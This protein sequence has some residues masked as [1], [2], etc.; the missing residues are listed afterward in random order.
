MFTVRIKTQD[1]TPGMLLA[2]SVYI[3]AS[4]ADML[5]ARKDTKLDA[6]KIKML[7]ER[8]VP[9]V[10]IV[11]PS[12][13]D[14]K[15]IIDEKLKEEAVDSVKQLFSCFG[16]ESCENKTTAYQ[17]VEQVEDVVDDLVQVLTDD[18]SGLVHIND[19]KSY[20]EYTYHH[21]LS[22][23]MLSIATGREL[24]LDND[25]LFRLG[26][27]AMMHDIGKQL[28]PIEIINKPGKLT[29]KE[30][31][32]IKSHPSLGAESL[33]QNGIGDKELWD[34]VRYHHEKING[35]GYPD[36]IKG[37]DLP[38]FSKI[39]SVVDVYDAVTSYRPYRSPMLPSEAFEII[40]KDIGTAFE[41]DIVK[42]FLAKLELY[43]VNTVV[44]LSNGKIG[45]V[46]QNEGSFRL[47]PTVCLQGTGEIL[48]LTASKNYDINISKVLDPR[49]I[50]A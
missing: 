42:A 19:L 39:I 35:T 23:S 38:L 6:A 26:R 14:V 44:E 15:K 49:E 22:V 25:T 43:P 27:C 11:S 16:T 7:V 9:Y 45:I 40:F 1:A 32:T 47:R 41:Y 12:A 34:G 36:R 13:P 37:G 4:G 28:I 8:N 20:D 46:V 48:T 17:L 10:A 5:A 29:D 3:S 33:K 24:G 18:A 31:D 2:E 21:S 50:P 30:F